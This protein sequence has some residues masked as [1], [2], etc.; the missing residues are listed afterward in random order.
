MS[1]WEPYPPAEEALAG[2]LEAGRPLPSSE[3]RGALGRRLIARD[4][5]YG[6]RPTRLRAMVLAYLAAG[7]A[8]LAVGALQ[9]GGQL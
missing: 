9:A 8:L 1:N 2:E 3:F 5:G 6:P 7:L 4:P